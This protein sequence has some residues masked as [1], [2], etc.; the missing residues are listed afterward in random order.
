MGIVLGSLYKRVTRDDVVEVSVVRGYG[1][2]RVGKVFGHESGV[3]IDEG[4]LSTR[5]ASFNGTFI[6]NPNRGQGKFL[7]R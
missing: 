6:Y 4:N 2:G 1:K 3:E 7:R 5:T